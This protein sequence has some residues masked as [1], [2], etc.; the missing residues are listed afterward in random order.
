MNKHPIEQN[1]V[2]RDYFRAMQRNTNGMGVAAYRRA[3]VACTG[4]LPSW[5]EPGKAGR[6]PKQKPAV[7][8]VD[9][10]RAA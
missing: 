5:A 9:G 3:M 1:T 4:T 6:K 7:L 8:P 2:E 10:Q